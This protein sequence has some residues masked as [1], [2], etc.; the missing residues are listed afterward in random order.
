MDYET[1]LHILPT[2]TRDLQSD[3]PHAQIQTLTSI[4]TLSEFCLPWTEPYFI[5]LVPSLIDSFSSKDLGVQKAAEEAGGSMIHH[6]SP[7]AVGLM[8]PPLLDGLD[9]FAWKCKT[10][11]LVLLKLLATTHPV[12]IGFHFPK[13]VPKLVQQVH[14][15]KQD[16]RDLARSALQ[17][18]CSVQDNPD[19]AP[20]LPDILNAY[21]DPVN[22]TTIAVDRLYSTS[23]IQPIDCAA[24]GLLIPVITRGM[25]HRMNVYKRRCAV[26]MDSICKLVTD[27]HDI[28]IFFSQLEA[29]LIQ[30][31]EEIDKEEVRHVCTRTLDTL[32]YVQK[33]A[34]ESQKRAIPKAD[35]L[36]A[37]STSLRQHC[38]LPDTD[39]SKYGDL[40]DFMA[41]LAE[42][43]ME[44]EDEDVEDWHHVFEPYLRAF[45]DRETARKISKDVTA[46]ANEGLALDQEVDEDTEEDLCNA[47]FSLAYGSR[48]L[49]HQTSLH[50]KRGR[51]YG[52]VG[53]NGA[54]K[55][56]LMR[57]IA[58]GNLQ[59]FPTDV[60][61]VYVE[62]DIQGNHSTT[63]VL[64]YIQNNEHVQAVGC[65][66]GRIRQQL[67]S[68]GFDE[69]MQS[70][71]VTSLSGGWRMKLA[72]S[73][74]ILTDPDMLLLDEP[75][76][77]LDK[78]A[79][80]WLLAYLQG[81]TQ[82]T[83][84]IVS[85]DTSFLDAICTDIIHYEKN[86]K[87][88][89]YRGN[90]S[91]FVKERPE[92]R[93]YYELSSDI[94]K[95]NFPSPGPLLGVKSLTKAVLKLSH[96]SFQY[97]GST[98]HQ[99]QDVS[100]QVS[101]VSRVAIIGA[102]GA[103]KSTL[104]KLLVGELGLQSGEL[105]RHPNVRIAYVAQHAFHHIEHHLDKSPCQYVMWRYSGGI[106]KEMS[107]RDSLQLTEAEWE[108]ILQLA[109]E[110]KTP[111]AE[112]IV[113]RIEGKRDLE[114]EVKW[115]DIEETQFLTRGELIQMG[116][117]KW[118][119]CF[120]EKVS[121]G[122]NRKLTTAE[123]SKHFE[124]FGLEENFTVHN[125]MG[126]LSGGQKVKVVLGAA[127][128]NKPHILILDEPT[129]FLDRDSLGALSLAIKDFEGGVLLISHHAEF[130][131]E[132]CNER[133]LLEGGRLHAEG[134]D[135]IQRMIKEK[136]P[137]E[138]EEQL[139]AFGNTIQPTQKKALD[140]SER[141]R[142]EKKRKEMIKN[143][144][145]TYE[146]D[147]LLGLA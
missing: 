24:L 93:S 36:T 113:G 19:I 27:P 79:C 65:G 140:R 138:E 147:E 46:F 25:K 26:I 117:Q 53:P 75:T 92:A 111:V 58:S 14:S 1:F 45:V 32:R 115:R 68:V 136:K 82:V 100:V 126:G 44:I 110:N 48:V 81:L 112:K 28:L 9:R 144:Q 118:V 73:R 42:V 63:S 22:C 62:H 31:Q 104:I 134:G 13:I 41:E 67:S 20:A 98:M 55:S 87:L 131:S 40:L 80:E 86:R 10:G 38:P 135:T 17:R 76:N 84:L 107:S 3:D 54:G 123:I 15:T 106:D 51:K 57:S 95:F 105:Y 132:L 43:L 85:H 23:F 103:G 88:K 130:Y 21:I 91:D 109:R 121:Q 5:K 124:E 34:S 50:L 90:L 52:L 64:E 127:M 108:R 72:L 141:K 125:N 33:E 94:V 133:W 6:L 56:T 49:L 102:N 59:G 12:K 78:L 30:G 61:T 4:K 16:V 89:R 77:H 39:L 29:I 66:E 35:M 116:Y 11:T 74:A 120:D 37:L 7:A 2:M 122:N 70:M 69:T 97:P 128:W 99:L 8:I 143:G 60:R 142:L 71:P 119:L 18:I 101:L 96:I 114:Y 47:E 83:C 137:L 129:N 146:I 139:D 145:D